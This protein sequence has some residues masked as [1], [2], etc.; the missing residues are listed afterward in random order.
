MPRSKNPVPTYSR[1]KPTDQ[2]YVRLP[3]GR[4]GRRVVY[5]GRYGSPESRTEYQR[6]LAELQAAPHAVPVL[7]RGRSHAGG[8]TVNEVLLAFM[9]W[10]MTHYRTPA[11]EPTSEIGELRWSLRPV[12]ELYGHTPASEFG[13]RALAAVRQNMIGRGWCRSLINHR[14]DRVKRVFKWATAEE[15]V[16]VAVY[17]ALRTLVGLR[18]GRT[19]VRESKPVGPVD[20][21]HVN[22]TLPFLTSHLRCMAELQRLTGMRPGEVCKLRLCEVDRTGD[23]WASRPS[24]HKT[25]HHGKTRVIHFGPRAQELIAAFLR[26]NNP[27]PDGFGHI[28]LNDP[29]QRDARL[30]MADAYQEAGRERDAELLR[31]PARVVVLV[32]GCVVDPT[33]TLF[34]PAR[35]REERFRAYRQK[36]KSKVQPSQV[37]RRKENP[38]RLP[39]AEYTPRTYAHAVRLAAKKANVPHWHPNQLRH[40]FATEVRKEHGLEAAQVMLGHSRADV[41]QVYAERDQ[42]LAASVA[43]RIG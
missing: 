25:A 26:G 10:A 11:G 29:D 40:L 20:P 23:V 27:P 18:K 13:P 30:V 32:G 12:R 34:S 19:E 1:H 42:T 37:S 14:I 17:Q 9:Q 15:L 24:Q 33:L 43:A 6:V 4:G 39:R 2:A 22:A 41:T 31:D 7:A 16:S 38:K 8:L 36:R 5:L 3:D 28:R 21:A 35:A